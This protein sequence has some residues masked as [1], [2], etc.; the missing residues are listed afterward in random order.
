MK[1]GGG[2][3]CCGKVEISI[4]QEVRACLKDQLSF[5]VVIPPYTKARAQLMIRK[6][7][8]VD[9]PFTAKFRKT[10]FDENGNKVETIITES[11]TWRGVKFLSSYIEVRAKKIGAEDSEYEILTEKS[12]F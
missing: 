9:V 6:A 10:R 2:N 1:G 11:G 8:N 7:D 3:L 4:L 5:Q 12:S